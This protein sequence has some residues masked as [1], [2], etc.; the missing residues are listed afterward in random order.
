MAGARPTESRL[1][2]RQHLHRLAGSTTGPGT[3]SNSNR[4]NAA[5]RLLAPLRR[6][7]GWTLLGLIVAVLATA[8]RFAAIGVLPPSINMKPFPHATAS[9]KL[10]LGGTRPTDTAG[11]ARA[12][13][14]ARH[15]YVRPG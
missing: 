6:H 15:A 7:R 10:V 3:G 14:R 12:L 5:D 11:M 8:T 1:G 2:A 13:Q 4:G 9:T